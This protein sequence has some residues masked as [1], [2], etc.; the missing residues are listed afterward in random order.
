MVSSPYS[1]TRKSRPQAQGTDPLTAPIIHGFNQ[2]PNTVSSRKSTA[3]PAP[4]TPTNR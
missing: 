4:N 2:A 3:V 1:P